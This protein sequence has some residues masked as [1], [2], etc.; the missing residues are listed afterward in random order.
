M[1]TT[2]R[3]STNGRAQIPN[4]V[5]VKLGIKEGDSL[6]ITIEQVVHSGRMEQGS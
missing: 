2:V 6:V 5:R 3:M 1:R 4:D